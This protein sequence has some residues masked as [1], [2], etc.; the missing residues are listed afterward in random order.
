MHWFDQPLETLTPEQWEALCDGCGQCCLNQLV[1]EEDNL[2]QTDIACRL[3]ATETARCSDYSNRTR[4]VPECVRLTPANLQ[5]VYF[6]PT[7]CAYRLRAQGQPLPEWHPLRHG[8][9][10]SAM[11]AAGYHVAGRCISEAT[12]D[13]KLEDR[14][15]TWPLPQS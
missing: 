15:V 4:R 10:K 5:Q 13:G 11:K 7:S 9:D 14:I 1:D 12:Y 2:Y 8:G 3:L 6:M